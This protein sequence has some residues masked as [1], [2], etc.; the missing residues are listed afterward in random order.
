[1]A[2]LAGILAAFALMKAIEPPTR[3]ALAA[4]ISGAS[5]RPVPTSTLE[6]CRTVT[7]SDPECAAAWEAKRHRFFGQEKDER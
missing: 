7:V 2:V 3:P 4:R 5:A 6:R 1:M